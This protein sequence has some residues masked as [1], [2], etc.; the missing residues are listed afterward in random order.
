[1]P[2]NA[3]MKISLGPVL[4]F[5]PSETLDAF[6]ECVLNSCV[7]IVYLGE[8]VCSK[9]RSYSM[10][11][12][13]EWAERL[14]RA[15]KEVVLSSL[16]LIESESELGAM[17]QL[18]QQGLTVEA[19]D[20]GIAQLA[21]ENGLPFVGGSTLNLYNASALAYMAKRGMQRW[22]PPLEMSRQSLQTLL[23]EYAAMG[24]KPLQTE[25]LGYGRL[26]LAHSARCYT[27]RFLDL[28]KDKCDFRCIDYPQGTPLV[29]QEGQGLFQING[30]QTQS[31]QVCNLLHE[32]AVMQ[33]MGISV[34]RFSANGI[35]CLDR[36]DAF[37]QQANNASPALRLVDEQS[38]N[39]YWY[40][41]PGIVWQENTSGF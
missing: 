14:T 21:I 36:I 25:I 17:K 3:E 26:P 2:A 40:G 34:F 20:T 29:S 7:D 9:R 23:A 41:K 31:F 4:Y 30:I 5:W 39:G 15:G 28:P 11:R 27:A 24:G 10:P 37:R 22:V 18:C 13:L 12:W 38:C 32:R 16:T 19:N 6:Y 33:Q 35:E 1:M 8:I